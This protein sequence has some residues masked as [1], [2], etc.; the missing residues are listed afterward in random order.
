MAFQPIKMT[1]DMR[2]AILAAQK[3][4]KNIED[5]FV[6]CTTNVDDSEERIAINKKEKK[7]RGK[8]RVEYFQGGKNKKDGKLIFKDKA[9]GMSYDRL[10]RV[11]SRVSEYQSG[12]SG[13]GLQGR[14]LKDIS[15]I[16][17]VN[18]KTLKNQKF[19]EVEVDIKKGLVTP[20]KK[21]E[22]PSNDILKIMGLKSLEHLHNWVSLD[23]F[24]KPLNLKSIYN[25]Q[26]KYLK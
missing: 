8:L 9:E 26:D 23:K 19:S 5:I 1:N 16:G 10:I 17:P 24:S 3:A 20:L 2:G 4:I 6:E 18:I 22:N 15:V 21:D 7:W 25:K 11:S 12:N 13:R 14:G